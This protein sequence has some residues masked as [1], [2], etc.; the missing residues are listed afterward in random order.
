[1]DSEER[2]RESLTKM[3]FKD[4]YWGYLF[5]NV[6]RVVNDTIPTLFGV[7][8][9]DE[10]HINLHYNPRFLDLS[11][12][13]VI[14]RTLEHEGF[15]LLD[16]HLIRL[17]RILEQ[18]NEEN[19]EQI[20][21]LWNY[22]AD[23]AANY[24]ANLPKSIEVG[25][26]QFNLIHAE[27]YGFPRGLSSEIYFSKLLDKLDFNNK[28]GGGGENGNK[29]S[30]GKN[31][32]RKLVG[33]HSGWKTEHGEASNF[34]E[35]KAE[36]EIN[37]LIYKSFK[38]VRDRGNLPGKVK[39]MIDEALKPP[40]VP[41][42][43]IIRKLVKGSRLSK[44]QKA[45]TKVNRKRLYSFFIDDILL[46]FP[47]TRRDMTFKIGVLLDTSG[48][49]DM[50]KIKEGLSGVKDIVEKDKDCITHV[51]ECDT[52]VQKEY[53]VKKISDIQYQI[54]GRGGTTLY[55]GLARLKELEVDVVLAFTDAYCENINQ[56]D[57]KLLPRK[58]IWVVPETSGVNTI[59]Q[60]G[61]IV[62]V[63]M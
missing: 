9:D 4:S 13:D 38:N 30:S 16:K 10:G 59:D 35:K 63:N 45:Y 1:M 11:K 47:G 37:D 32:K 55:P 61:Y 6:T 36:K 40:K 48:S 8:I 58:I 39:E 17:N 52:Q 57:R 62:R 21:E 56:I 29:G 24:L 12:D 43:Y 14:E 34:V 3:I 50:E 7:C 46:P 31:V 28:N 41:Y 33:D 60:T 23:M 26:V 20:I 54:K 5:S 51:V 44:L 49:M 19:H 15:H 2:I 42:Y 18:F 53:E 25:G 22:A 27:D